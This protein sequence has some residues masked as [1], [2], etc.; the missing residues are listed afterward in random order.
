MWWGLGDMPATKNAKCVVFFMY[1]RYSWQVGM[2]VL[3]MEGEESRL[4]R[5]GGCRWRHRHFRRVGDMMERQGELK[6]PCRV[7]M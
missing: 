7:L 4:V 5:E 1:S 3:E 2:G 6:S